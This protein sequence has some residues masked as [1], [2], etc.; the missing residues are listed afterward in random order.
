MADR[1]T[2]ANTDAERV[3]LARQAAMLAPATTRL[4]RAAGIGN[5]MT[6]LDVG[7]GAGDVA[8]L[9]GELVGPNG[10]VVAF[11]RDDHQLAAATA[12]FESLPQVE[13]VHGTV[14]DPPEGEF[15]AVVGRLVLMYQRDLDTAVR[16]LSGRVRAGGA[17]AFLEQNL[18]LGAAQA[19]YWPPFPLA[20]E[21]AA[22]IN[23]GFTATSTQLLTGIRLP[24]AFRA[25]GLTP[26]PPYESCA[27]VYEGRVRAEM[28]AGLVRSMLPVLEDAA[29]AQPTSTSTRSPI[30]STPPA[31]TTRSRLS[32]P[33]LGVWARKPD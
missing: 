15:D 6:V 21:V 11:D 7:C 18:R 4:F 32:G 24:S 30:A 1:Y 33:M 26:Q 27:F 8:A 2:L 19:I 3:R 13:F 17:M 20:D 14:E 28:T 16:V 10:R 25:A 9:V 5:G 12:R 23:L 29:S 31:A 22:W